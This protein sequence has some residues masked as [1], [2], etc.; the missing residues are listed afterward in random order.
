MFN[1]AAC[2]ASMKR[3]NGCTAPP[4][5]RDGTEYT[6]RFPPERPEVEFDQCPARVLAD[7]PDVVELFRTLN[8]SGSAISADSQQDLPY[9]FIEALSLAAYHQQA[10]STWRMQQTQKK[11][12]AKHGR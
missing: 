6:W 10:K 2:T 11:A 7:S 4:R 5:R 9:P 3:A 1:C 12:R 8:L